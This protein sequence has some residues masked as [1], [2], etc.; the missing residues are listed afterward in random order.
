[1]AEPMSSVLDA[2]KE[3]LVDVVSTLQQSNAEF[4]IV[5]GWSPYLLN[6]SKH[7]HPGTK[8]VDV[9]FSDES[10]RN[11]LARHIEVLLENGFMPSAKH[12]FQLLKPIEVAGQKLVFN[13]DLLHPSE[14]IKNPELFADQFNLHIVDGEVGASKTIRSIVLPSSKIL[15]EAGFRE[16]KE[17]VAPLTSKRAVIPLISAAGSILSKCE[18]VSSTK[19]RRDSFDIYVS[20]L[21]LGVDN[22]VRAISPYRSLNGVKHMTEALRSYLSKPSD[23]DATITEFDERVSYFTCEHMYSKPSQLVSKLLAA[24]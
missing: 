15:F 2:A 3:L 17:V 8:D 24:I 19:R 14:T 11:G 9:L 18:S 6:T 16:N 5:G 21:T 12:D 22:A 13:I 4:V 1:M 10:A 23:N 7:A 20:L